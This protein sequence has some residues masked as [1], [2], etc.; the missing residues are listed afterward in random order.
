MAS[1][2]R[3]LKLAFVWPDGENG[4]SF[5]ANLDGE[6]VELPLTTAECFRLA[7]AFLQAGRHLMN[8]P[9]PEK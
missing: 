4:F 3:K 7:S 1:I 6:M 8:V 2:N 9:E 5:K